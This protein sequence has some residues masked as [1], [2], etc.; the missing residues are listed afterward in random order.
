MGRILSVVGLVL[1]GVAFV[2]PSAT[3]PTVVAAAAPEIVPP[4]PDGVYRYEIRHSVHG[5]IGTRTITVR[6]D[7]DT[8]VLTSEMRIA[9]KLGIITLFK[10][11]EDLT[12]V[13]RDGRLQRFEISTQVQNND[14][15]TVSGRALDSG[16]ALNTSDGLVT[17]PPDAMP[18]HSWHI[19]SLET[20]TWVDEDAASILTVS[21]GEPVAETII[22][23]DREIEARRYEI[24][25]DVTRTQ[26]YDS[27]GLWLRTQL[28]NNGTV[29]IERMFE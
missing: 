1:A 29:T 4:G 15:K 2:L 3:I 5:S 24:T 28:Q 8:R 10:R 27:D 13:W 21:V 25:G 7:G 11:K 18:S 20:Q 16:I 26:W 6:T 12:E 17:A 9:V 19:A 14:P 22:I 23:G